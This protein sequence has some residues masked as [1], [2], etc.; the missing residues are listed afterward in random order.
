[1]CLVIQFYVTKQEWDHHQ[2]QTRNQN[3]Y[4]IFLF[5]KGRVKT[6]MTMSEFLFIESQAG[7]WRQK[8]KEKNQKRRSWI[9]LQF[10]K[11]RVKRSLH[12]I[13]DAMKQDISFTIIY[14][15]MKQK[16]D[17]TITRCNKAKAKEL[18]TMQWSKRMILQSYDATK[19]KQKNYFYNYLPCN[20][21]EN[22]VL[23][24]FTMQ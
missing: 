19:Q 13:Y 22:L 5:R 15:A 2:Q 11:V 10:E 8:T 9:I 16:N 1:M 17:F 3:M 23:W 21:A 12:V 14:D 18:F 20:E 24:L 6:I 4:E 7:D